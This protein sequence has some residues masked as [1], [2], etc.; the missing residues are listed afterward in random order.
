MLMLQQL[1]VACGFLAMAFGWWLA[2]A[3]RRP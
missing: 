2:G 1:I 3:R